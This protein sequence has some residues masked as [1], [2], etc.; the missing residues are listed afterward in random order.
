MA[1]QKHET[2]DKNV[3]LKYISD[4]LFQNGAPRRQ[5]FMEELR[6]KCSRMPWSLQLANYMKRETLT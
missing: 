4:D 1:N 2:N 6:S 3:V 5:K